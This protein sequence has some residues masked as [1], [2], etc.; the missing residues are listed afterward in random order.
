[1]DPTLSPLW[2]WLGGLFGET[3]KRWILDRLARQKNIPRD[4]RDALWLR[5]YTLRCGHLK[6]RTLASVFLAAREELARGIS[7]SDLEA[8]L[9]A[10]EAFL[11]LHLGERLGL[12]VP[13]VQRW[14]IRARRSAQAELEHALGYAM[15]RGLVVASAAKG[16]YVLADP[17][18]Q[19][20]ARLQEA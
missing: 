6:G 17:G 11:R 20:I 4:Q 3:L 7:G 9:S 1:M 2:K 8:R 12:P 19:A 10:A 18:H 16:I 13:E 5:S 14:Q 15:A